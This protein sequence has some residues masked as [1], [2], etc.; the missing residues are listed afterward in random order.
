MSSAVSTPRIFTR[1]IQAV[2]ALLALIMTAGGYLELKNGQLSSAAAIYAEVANYSAMLCALFYAVGLTVLK[3]HVRVP[4]VAHQR[5]VD[6]AVVV[7]LAIGGV[8]HLTSEAVRDC[9]SINTMFIKYHKSGL[10]SCSRMTSSIVLTFVTMALF[11][12]TL[13]WSFVADA[14]PVSGSVQ[15]EE[16]AAA[17]NVGAYG[18]VGTPSM[19]A[20]LMDSELT[21]E[22]VA[23]YSAARRGGRVLQ[24]VCSVAALVTTVAG[25]RHYYTGQYVSASATY[26]ILMSYTCVLYSLWHVAAVDGLK[27][28]GAPK[29][30][31]ERMLDGLLAVAFVVGGIMFATSSRVTS[32]D[33]LNTTFQ[34]NHGADPLFRCGAMDTG[35]VFTFIAVAM[36]L[37]TFLLSFASRSR[38][39]EQPAQQT[40]SLA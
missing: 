36:F 3:S 40:Q 38:V 34:V 27:V 31:L 8:V 5:I 13:V 16:E 10:F 17:A 39:V 15:N 30:S 9:T 11:V 20:N 21:T 19:K 6:A 24:L 22:T 23:A 28:C 33:E 4:T 12:V 25:Y 26:V 35:V 14:K 29:L 7:A 1:T 37:V 18:E 2:S 32:C